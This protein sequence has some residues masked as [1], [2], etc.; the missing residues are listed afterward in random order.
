MIN[1]HVNARTNLPTP[2]PPR[3]TR[4]QKI[5]F[6]ASM[7]KFPSAKISKTINMLCKHGTTN[8]NDCHKHITPL[9]PSRLKFDTRLRKV[10]QINL[11]A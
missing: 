8:V 9:P 3:E 2:F 4:I 5:G 6:V 11:A 1:N 7:L 10:F